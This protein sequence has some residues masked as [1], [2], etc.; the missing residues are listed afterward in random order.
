MHLATNTFEVRA[1][2]FKNPIEKPKLKHSHSK[3][4]LDQKTWRTETTGFK[5]LE[6]KTSLNYYEL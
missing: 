1:G 2:S 4:A 6:N 5:L 3:H